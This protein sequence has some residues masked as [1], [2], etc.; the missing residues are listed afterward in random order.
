MNNHTDDEIAATEHAA[1]AKTWGKAFDD[2]AN[3]LQR[4]RDAVLAVFEKL[5][6]KLGVL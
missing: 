3:A 5:A 2:L 6:K 1:Y 4:L